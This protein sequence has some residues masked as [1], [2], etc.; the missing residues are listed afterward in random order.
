MSLINYSNRIICK[1]PKRKNH[2]QQTIECLFRSQIQELG[3]QT[4]NDF[5]ACMFYQNDSILTDDLVF[6]LL[7][8][9]MMLVDRIQRTRSRTVKREY[10]FYFF[11]FSFIFNI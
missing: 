10:Y 5:N 2:S 4:L 8:I 3:Q 1:L 9:S 6:K 11:I 7:S